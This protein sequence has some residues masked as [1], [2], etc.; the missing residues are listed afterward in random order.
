MEGEHQSSLSV[1]FVPDNS[2]DVRLPY[3]TV[4]APLLQNQPVEE[5]RMKSGQGSP[6]HS[7]ILPPLLTVHDKSLERGCGNSHFAYTSLNSKEN[8]LLCLFL[9]LANCNL[10][11]IG[12]LLPKG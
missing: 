11:K 7:P 8:L 5:E 2:M 12:R 10:G 1:A 3:M 4:V 6:A 9:Q